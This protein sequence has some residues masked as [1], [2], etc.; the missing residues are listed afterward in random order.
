MINVKEIHE[1]KRFKSKATCTSLRA[2]NKWGVIKFP[3]RAKSAA[4]IFTG[5]AMEPVVVLTVG[6]GTA[7]V[8]LLLKRFLS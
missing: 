2:Q 7:K 5:L 1:R 3:M 4:D 8:A 6:H